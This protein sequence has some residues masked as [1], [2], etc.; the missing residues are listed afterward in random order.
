MFASLS[1][2]DAELQGK[3][4]LKIVTQTYTKKQTNKHIYIQK[5]LLKKHTVHIGTS[6]QSLFAFYVK[7]HGFSPSPIKIDFKIG[8]WWVSNKLTALR[9]KSYNKTINYSLWCQ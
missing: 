9:E 5:H 7:D 4:C 3:H 6:I 2:S 8:I 1:L